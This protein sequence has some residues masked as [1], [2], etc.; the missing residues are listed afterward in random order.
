[1]SIFS[2]YARYCNLLYQNKEYVAEAEFILEY[3]ARHGSMLALLGF[4]TLLN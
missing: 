2:D 1:M 4:L 3:L